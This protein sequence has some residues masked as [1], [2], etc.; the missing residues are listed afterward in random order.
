[1]AMASRGFD[2]IASRLEAIYRACGS[3]VTIRNVS[4]EPSSAAAPALLSRATVMG[5][6]N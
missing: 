4:A 5:G 3:G 6:S 1:V 2:R